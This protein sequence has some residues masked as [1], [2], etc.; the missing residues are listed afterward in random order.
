LNYIDTEAGLAWIKEKGRR[1]RQI[2]LPEMLR[3]LLAI[4][5]A[6]L[7]L[8]KGPLFL[9]PRKKRISPRILFLEE[10]FCPK[11]EPSKD[12]KYPVSLVF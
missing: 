12:K 4:Y 1:Q 5:I 2:V 11:N 7:H 3:K 8:D 10:L 9:S 6:R